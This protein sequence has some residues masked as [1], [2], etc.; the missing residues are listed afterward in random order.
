MSFKKKLLQSQL[1]G[2]SFGLPI[3][4][5]MAKKDSTLQFALISAIVVSQLTFLG[6]VF[7]AA[8]AVSKLAFNKTNGAAAKIGGIAIGI[9]IAAMVAFVIGNILLGKTSLVEQK[10]HRVF[11]D[12]VCAEAVATLGIP[13]AI[14]FIEAK[15]YKCCTGNDILKG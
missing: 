15:I 1:I 9:A 5:D 7:G 8:F 12:L 4:G 6:I 13:A 14:G 2:T 11:E 10:D 3:A